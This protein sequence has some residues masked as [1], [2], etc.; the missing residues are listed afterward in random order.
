LLLDEAIGSFRGESLEQMLHVLAAFS[1]DGRQILISTS[2][3]YTARRIAAHGGTVSRMQEIMRFARPNYVLDGQLDLGLHPALERSAIV[4]HAPDARPLQFIQADGYNYEL[5]ELNRQ[6]AGLANEQ[7]VNTW[8]YPDRQIAQPRFAEPISPVAS[9]KRFYLYVDSPV[10]DAPGIDVELTH[11]L[12][13]AGI[14][15]VSDLLRASA[16][17][18]GTSIRVAP[19]A[20]EHIQRVA[21]LMCATPGLRAFDAQV[22]VGCGITRSSSLREFAASDLIHRIEDFLGSA[23]G[24][25]LIRTASSFEV[26]RLHGWI[27]E[28]KRNHR[29]RSPY[30]RNPFENSRKV[31]TPR[32]SRPLRSEHEPLAEYDDEIHPRIARTT[33]FDGPSPA[34]ESFARAPRSESQRAARSSSTN[35]KSTSA[36]GSQWKFYLDIESPVVDAPSIGPKMAEKLAPLGVLTVG[37][38]IASDASELATQ[39]AERAVTAETVL[40]WQ[41]Q[42]LLVCRVPNLRGH[43]AQLIVGTGLVTAEQVASADAASLHESV[44]RFAN[45]KAG[46]RILRGASS[47]DLAEVADWI[48]WAHNCRAVRA[49]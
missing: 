7:A 20:L 48:Q 36:S 23:S 12:N 26:S 35:T 5:G 1:R 15:R 47:P 8:W 24:Q 13:H 14:F 40:Q 30:E 49:A 22:L 28:M 41:Q 16:V 44:T 25:D 45:T 10:Q 21:E 33:D 46:L 42:S 37:D 19:N 6:L 9:S 18:L 3:E 17:K 31:R 29:L 34:Q 27:S 43:D 38:L 39:L 11:R 2:D 4:A 32:P